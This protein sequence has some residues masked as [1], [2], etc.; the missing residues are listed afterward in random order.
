MGLYYDRQG[1]PIDDVLAWGLKMKDPNYKIV[2][3]HTFRIGGRGIDIAVSTVWL[4]IDHG[5]NLNNDPNYRPII[6]ET[7]VFGLSEDNPQWR[8]CTE[9]EAEE[10]HAKVCLNIYHS[11]RE[12]EGM[13]VEVLDGY[14]EEKPPPF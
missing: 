4:G 2:R 8:Y 5:W 9:Q 6:F 13:P 1:N 10:G 12:G 11:L 14:M 7:M 3:Q